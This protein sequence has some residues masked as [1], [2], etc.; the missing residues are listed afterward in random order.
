MTPNYT[1]VHVK[2]KLDGLNYTYNDLMEVAYS[3]VKEGA[4]YQQ[5]L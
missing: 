5:E 4:P 1:N 2:F 3:Y